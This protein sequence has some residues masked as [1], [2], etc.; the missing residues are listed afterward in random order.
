MLGGR[1]SGARGPGNCLPPLPQDRSRRQG[2]PTRVCVRM[3][4]RA[5]QRERAPRALAP[6]PKPTCARQ[7]H[8]PR[9]V[10]EHQP[11]PRRVWCADDSSGASLPKRSRAGRRQSL[12]ENRGDFARGP[13]SVR[14]RGAAECVSQQLRVGDRLSLAPGSPSGVCSGKVVTRA[15]AG[16]AGGSSSHPCSPGG[17]GADPVVLPCGRDEGSAL[18]CLALITR[19]CGGSGMRKPRRNGNRFVMASLAF[20]GDK[21]L[22]ARHLLIMPPGTHSV[23]IL[24]EMGP[25]SWGF[26]PTELTVISA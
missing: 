1:D 26:V 16:A 15:S 9:P 25:C 22:G 24:E 11:S 6:T 20:R 5:C 19:G 17:E 4:V 23:E 12:S 2:S 14:M 21:S 7:L 3:S 18:V 8:L 10:W 13:A